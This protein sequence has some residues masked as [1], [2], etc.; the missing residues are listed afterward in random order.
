MNEQINKKTY[1]II[2]A[3]MLLTDDALKRTQMR[4]EDNPRTT[5]GLF[6]IYFPHVL[7]AVSNTYPAL[8]GLYADFLQRD[9]NGEGYPEIY[10]AMLEQILD[11]EAIMND[12]QFRHDYRANILIASILTNVYSEKDKELADPYFFLIDTGDKEVEGF[13]ELTLLATALYGRNFGGDFCELTR[14]EYFRLQEE[15]FGEEMEAVKNKP[16][17]RQRDLSGYTIFAEECGVVDEK[18]RNEKFTPGTMDDYIQKNGVQIWIGWLSDQEMSWATQDKSSL[19]NIIYS[20]FYALKPR[21]DDDGGVWQRM[22]GIHK[23]ILSLAHM[24]AEKCNKPFDVVVSGNFES[25]RTTYV[26]VPYEV[27]VGLFKKETRYRKE[28]KVE[29]YLENKQI[30]FNGWLLEHFER[31]N[32]DGA[33]IS[34]D[35]C[36]GSDGQLYVI[37]AI[38]KGENKTI[39]YKVSE[40]LAVFESFFNIPNHRTFVSVSHG[41][42][43]ALDAVEIKPYHER[44]YD[45]YINN[46]K[47]I[48]DFPLHLNERNEYPFPTEGDGL[49][50]RLRMLAE[51]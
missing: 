19:W 34:W 26:D 39:Q 37:T 30:R 35:Y 32:E 40:M 1:A 2:L 11:N 47:Y 29:T 48:L 24:A 43:G 49:K 18:Y 15:G 13:S 21:L 20:G 10:C 12:E 22:R 31:V 17:E 8:S 36:L 42:M 25:E 50:T 38:R 27:K 7:E 51:Q 16:V 14:Q 44:Q 9:K 23:G 5:V 45:T 3:K 28:P 6:V 33:K 41:W 4:F 46:E